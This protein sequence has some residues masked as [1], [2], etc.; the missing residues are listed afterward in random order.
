MVRQSEIGPH[1]YGAEHGGF[2]KGGEYTHLA[3]QLKASQISLRHG[4]TYSAIRSVGLLT[5]YR[6]L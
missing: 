5:L 2:I 1:M 3:D 6:L 4:D